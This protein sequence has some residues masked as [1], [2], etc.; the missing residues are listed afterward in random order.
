M[1]ERHRVRI[2]PDSFDEQVDVIRHEAV[3]KDDDIEGVGRSQNL[4]QRHVDHRR[5]N[6]A[7]SSLCGAKRKE[8]TL[9]AD[10]E[11][12]I[13]SRAFVAHVAR[14]VQPARLGQP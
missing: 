4:S 7:A 14:L 3:R 6:E 5:I 2:I 1:N 12:R 10:V 9:K 8:I 13:E 11:G